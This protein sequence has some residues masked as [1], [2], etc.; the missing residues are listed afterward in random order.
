MAHMEITLLGRFE[1]IVDG[2][3][4]PDQI[5][6]R[7]SAAALVKLLA[8]ARGQRLHREQVIDAL[9]PDL[10]VEDA[11]PRLHKATHFARRALGARDAVEVHGEVI[12][13]GGS[14]GGLRVDVVDFERAAGAALTSEQGDALAAALA[15]YGGTL[16]PDDL[17]EAWT[18]D[19]RRHLA[20]M[21]LQLLRAAGRWADVVAID[22]SDEEAHVR[23]MREHA[24]R[25]DRAGG[26]R[27]FERLEHALRRE[28]GVAPGREALALRAQLLRLPAGTPA[29]PPGGREASP[30]L[31]GRD[32][33][34]AAF[35]A[36]LTSA[37]DGRGGTVF[38]RGEAGLGK[39][40]TLEWVRRRARERGWRSGQGGA[41]DVVG[42]W[43][44]APVLEALSDLCRAHPT[45][46]DGLDDA[47]RD[48]V[49]RALRGEAAPWSG[50]G[51]HQKLFVATAELLRLAAAGSGAMLVVDDAHEADEASLRLLH[52][53]AR[54]AIGE[55]ML[56]VL[57]HR[58]RAHDARHTT[59]AGAG[60]VLDRMRETLL[61]RR[62]AVS[63]DLQPLDRP[64]VRELLARVLGRPPEPALLDEVAAVTGGVPLQVVEL[65]RAIGDGLGGLEHGL[66]ASVLLRGLPADVMESLRRVA[67]LGTAFDTDE[68]VAL[69]EVP[70][71]TGYRQLD[72][73]L[74]TGVL[75]RTETGFRLRHAVVREALLA[76]VPPHR[77]Q[78][79]HR[80]AAA[81]LASLHVSPA[82]V[83][84][85]HVRGGDL[86]AAVPWVLAAADTSAALGAYR[87]SLDLVES[88]R[89]GADGDDLARLL[90]LR[91]DL[92]L[93]VSDPGAVPAYREAL[94]V[95]TGESRRRVRARLARAA[96][97]EGD[98]DTAREA[99]SG[100]EAHDD[101]TL[102]L[103]RGTFAY[104]SGDLE[105]AAAASREAS[106][107]VADGGD[108]QVLDLV[109]LQGLVAHD[110]GE[111]FA[112]LRHELART[113]NAPV[114]ASLVFD[115][116]LCVAEYLLYGPT[117]YDEVLR[118]AYDLRE[119]AER[120]GALR[121]VAFASTLA[122]EAALLSGDLP[123]AERELLRAVELH[124]GIAA[125][126]GEAHSLQ[127]LAELRLLQGDR[128][129]ARR[130]LRQ[131]FPLARWGM[132]P[133]HLL[134]RIHGALIRAA[135]DPDEAR[136]VVARAE[137]I[138]AVEDFCSFCEVMYEVPAAIA[139]A[140]A[141]DL[142]EAR[143]HL[144]SARRS[145]A[146]WQGTAWEAATRE[147]EAHLAAAEGDGPAADRL[148]ER[149]AAL[150]AD[151]GQ[152]LDAGRCRSA[153]G[154][155]L[156]GPGRSAA[157]AA[158][159]GPR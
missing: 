130:L 95:A 86:R 152:P 92:L 63:V 77:V 30:D 40:A 65:A 52:Y 73:A 70:E 38:V 142:D 67:V 37:E 80:H 96:A 148:L 87:D 27:Q 26:L 128:A 117:P 29:E 154:T 156:P 129:D 53:L 81:V 47:Y 132:R 74:A 89:A 41:S 131:A 125:V 9:W 72:V 60:E 33:E 50:A 88:V 23:L 106:L 2:V 7:R 31:V 11:G 75:R 155:L 126:S 64:A 102:L 24:G 25:G 98:L 124:R 140:T 51:G 122:G 79:L 133:G 3:R 56:V 91:A 110:R 144:E 54:T 145:T 100:L 36:A 150:F 94:E 18:E 15:L 13:L 49:E 8:L 46:M 12:A 39:S 43:P 22:P 42:T 55:R 45:L 141:G 159:A 138:T 32:R 105:G 134:P 136:D 111:W 82:R 34:L 158:F 127:R 85:H 97:L 116:H 108:W 118:L 135:D 109:S 121:A 66:T 146:L 120:T 35:V 48:E 143:R 14:H 20:E 76:D 115:A 123:V 104:F 90:L 119:T 101:V 114:I 83:G 58:T 147:A 84:H 103:A 149:A 28:L 68:F 71:E 5:W 44:Y 16:L 78:A 113:R 93:A 153:V 139:C 1:V 62:A 17:Y 6:S 69:A 99:L 107:R 112:R 61:A 157:T 57:A 151:A 19:A 21:H 59:N 4:V 10:G 137:A